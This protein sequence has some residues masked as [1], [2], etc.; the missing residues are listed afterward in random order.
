[1]SLA[2]QAGTSVAMANSV[3]DAI[4]AADSITDTNDN[5]GVAKAIMQ[6]LLS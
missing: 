5:D 3:M 1:L 6:Y 4:A 2:T